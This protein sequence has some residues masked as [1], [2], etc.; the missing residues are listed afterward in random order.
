MDV[1]ADVLSAVRVGTTV[2]AQAELV[3][4]WGLE[5][6]PVAQLMSTSFSGVAVGC[7]RPV[8]RATSISGPATWS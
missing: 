4:P 8:S 3:P 7:A 1:L 5:I 2:V 6:D